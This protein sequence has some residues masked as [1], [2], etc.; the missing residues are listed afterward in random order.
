ME[1]KRSLPPLTA[2]RAFEA[3]ARRKSFK[4][5]ANELHVTPSAVSHAVAA[6]E[7]F[8]GVKLF[9]RRVRRLLLTDAGSAYLTPLTRAFDAISVATREVSARKRADLVTV[10]SMPTFTR[11]WLMPRLKAFLDGQPDVDLRVRATVDFA[12]MV[13]DD[14]DAAIAY[15]RGDWRGFVVDR[16]LEERM[17]PLCSPT[18]RDGAPPLRTPAD[19]AQHRLIHTE[20]KLVTWAMWLEAAGVADVNMHRGPRFNRADLA[21][22]AAIAGLGVALDNPMFAGPHLASGALVIP[23]EPSLALPD[24]GGYY[25]VCRP[26]KAALPKVEA[27]R[28]W[29]IEAAGVAE[30]SDGSSLSARQDGK[31]GAP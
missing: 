19:L 4:L 5:A 16:L 2:L 17:V 8:L 7:E 31:F 29:I 3:A 12:E 10:A 21:L 18:L 20:T 27:F 28:R 14:I 15:G 11:V 25:F 26:E 23:F 9:H 30:A 22:E 24:L 1:T 6:L 13:A